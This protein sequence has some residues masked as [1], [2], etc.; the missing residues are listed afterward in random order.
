ME[1]ASLTP[2]MDELERALAWAARPINI[3]ADHRIVP[4]IQTSGRRRGLCGWFL[5]NSWSTREGDLCH[6]VN[7]AAEQ[8]DRPVED[9]VE[10]AIHE[11]AH[12]WAH[13]LDLKDCSAA[14]RHNKVFK[15]HAEALGLVCAPPMDGRG[16]AYTHSSPDL[17]A[18]IAQELQ[19]DVGK[20]ALFRLGQ[21]S[22]KAP[23]K[24]K[25][26]GCGCTI[27]RCATGLDATCDRC[28]GMFEVVV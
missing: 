13:S 12:L 22:R 25:K 24:M 28:G 16:Y 21:G 10:T 4:T 18:R 6:E 17:L 15:K 5:H 9:I 2:A 23:T 19:P 1:I 26:W 27:V 7:F 3:P 11:L 8:L 14:G 20:F